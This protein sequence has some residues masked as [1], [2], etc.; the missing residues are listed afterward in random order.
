[1]GVGDA[2]ADEGLGEKDAATEREAKRMRERESRKQRTRN[3]REQRKREVGEGSRQYIVSL[4]SFRTD[5]RKIEAKL[6]R[7]L[8]RRLFSRGARPAQHTKWDLVLSGKEASEISRA[9]GKWCEEPASAPLARLARTACGAGRRTRAAAMCDHTSR[10]LSSG[11]FLLFHCICC[12]Q[13]RSAFFFL[14]SFL[15]FFLFFS[16][17][18]L[19]VFECFCVCVGV[20]VFVFVCVCTVCKCV[21]V[22]YNNE[23]K[24]SKLNSTRVNF[25]ILVK[26]LANTIAIRQLAGQVELTA[27]WLKSVSLFVFSYKETQTAWQFLWRK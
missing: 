8:S 18:C 10:F 14:L 3:E 17:V 25:R 9:N 12:M 5:E 15:F 6:R 2:L 19:Y 4:K 16:F 13:F 23:T 11:H 1:M 21:H 22:S 27:K 26:L 24:Y 7:I 20:Y